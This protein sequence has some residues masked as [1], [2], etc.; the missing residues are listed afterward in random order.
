MIFR[1]TR[2]FI[3]SYKLSTMAL[4]MYATISIFKIIDKEWDPYTLYLSSLFSI[5]FIIFGMI[6]YRKMNYIAN[7]PFL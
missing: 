6:Y 5:L 2:Y 1:Y 4:F 3:S 7:N